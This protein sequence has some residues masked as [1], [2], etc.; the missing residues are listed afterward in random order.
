MSDLAGFVWT[1]LPESSLAKGYRVDEAGNR[2]DNEEQEAEKRRRATAAV[3][4]AV[5][6]VGT[7]DEGEAM[8]ITDSVL[9]AFARGDFKEDTVV[10]TL[11]EEPP[12][13]GVRLDRGSSAPSGS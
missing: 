2:I 10:A 8:N 13:E 12:V 1:T 4:C 11:P 6:I 9:S 5:G 7:R 3:L